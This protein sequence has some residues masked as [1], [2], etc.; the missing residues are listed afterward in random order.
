MAGGLLIAALLAAAP[1]A[2]GAW[3]YDRE[4]N[5]ITI[6]RGSATL[7]ALRA[8]LPGAPLELVDRGRRVWLLGADLEIR[9]GGALRLHGSRI[10]GDVDE[11]R[12]KS[13]NAR[14]PGSFVSITADYGYIDIRA[15]KV[16]SWDTVRDAPDTEH[17]S[18]GRAFIRVRSRLRSMVLVP[19]QSRMDIVDSEIAYLGHAANESYGLVWKVVA[20]QPYVLNHVRVYGSVTG[21]RIHHNYFGLYASGLRG[22]EWRGNEVHH[23]HRYG[24]APHQRSDDLRIEDNHVHDNGSHGISVRED[25]ARPVIRGNRA[26]ANRGSGITVHRGV[27]GAVISGNEASLNRQAGIVV[28]ASHRARVH[29]NLVRGNAIAGVQLAMGSADGTIENNEMGG[30]G[31]Y[32]LFVGPGKGRPDPPGQA[33]PVRNLITGN[34][35]YGSGEQDVRPGDPALNRFVAN[36]V[37]ESSRPPPASAEPA[38]PAEPAALTAASP[39]PGRGPVEAFLLRLQAWHMGAE[40]QWG[41]ALALLLAL[42]LLHGIVRRGRD[43]R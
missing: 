18:F 25:C 42:H 21:S 3:R 26:L 33:L 17:E 14:A 9:H 34:V 23:N 8:A 37:L 32:G 11:L 24:I 16:T 10:G 4:R 41:G 1:V 13:D 19:L 2:E 29:D 22:G 7:S 40:V 6:E 20:P 43:G 36:T 39:P 38:P 27:D 28:Y 35:I 12:L 31:V 30:N 15:T 5:L